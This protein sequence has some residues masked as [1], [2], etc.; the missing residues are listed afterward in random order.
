M[1]CV[2]S[3]AFLPFKDSEFDLVISVNVLTQ[4]SGFGIKAKK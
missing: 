4:L 1:L 2:S 3:G